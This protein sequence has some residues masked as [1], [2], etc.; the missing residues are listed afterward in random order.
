[1]C[2]GARVAA[3]AGSAGCLP[4]A[5]QSILSRT[6]WLC[7]ENG[8]GSEILYGLSIALVA[9]MTSDLHSS[10]EEWVQLV[11]E[12]NRPTGQALRSLMRA[13]GLLHRATFIFVYGEDGRLFAQRRALQKD[14]Y[15]GYWDAAA[16][17]VMRPGETYLDNATREVRE[18]LGIE[19]EHLEEADEFLFQSTNYRVWGRSFVVRSDG[20]FTFTDDEVSEGQFVTEQ[21]L[22]QGELAPV[23]PD[24]LYALRRLVAQ[25]RIK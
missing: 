3:V 14:L 13:N 25:R 16:G 21:G 11:D 23:T 1:M 4:D 17:G 2:V 7:N 5:I 15:P 22:L 10:A 24:S 20:P 18:E 9:A 6:V 8:H 12:N 19:P